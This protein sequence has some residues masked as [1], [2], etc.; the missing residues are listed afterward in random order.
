M[1]KII[2]DWNTIY[3][4]QEVETMGWYY[5]D[6]DPDLELVIKQKNISSG[7]FLD[8]GTGPATQ[9]LCLSKLGFQVTGTDISEKAIEDA[10]LKTDEIKFIHDD[11]INTKLST[12]FDYV[13]DRGCF[14]VFND[15]DRAKYLLT[16]KKLIKKNGFL[17]LKCFSDK[18][19]EYEFGPNPY[20]EDMIEK[21]FSNDFEIESITDTVYH[22][23]R[24]IKPKALFGIMRKK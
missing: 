22:G 11:I 4:E 2:H 10:I 12:Q 7:T 18:N 15:E 21:L 9:A 19:P 3:N 1:A 14:H 16:I 8:V 6:L 23:T 5:P 20:S 24:E 17:F 13:L